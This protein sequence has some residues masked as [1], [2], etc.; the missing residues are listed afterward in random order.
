LAL[1]VA[2]KIEEPEV[3]VRLLEELVE[4]LPN[5]QQ[6]GVFHEIRLSACQ[7]KYANIR[8]QTLAGLVKHLPPDQVLQVTGQIENVEMRARTLAALVERLPSEQQPAVIEEAI[9]SAQH[10]KDPDARTRSLAELVDRLPAEQ[11]LAVARQ[12]EDPC[13]RVRAL[14]KSVGRVPSEQQLGVFQEALSAAEQIQDAFARDQ[15][16]VG[17]VE[18]LPAEQAL[19]VARQIKNAYTR[20]RTLRWLVEWL[21]PKQRLLFADEAVAALLEGIGNPAANDTLKSVLVMLTKRSL[22][23]ADR[24]WARLLQ[25]LPLRGRS[26]WLDNLAS[27]LPLVEHLGGQQALLELTN[28]IIDVRRRWP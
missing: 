8:E 10:I 4:R 23:E 26:K 19:A 22:A 27:S 5:E 13:T 6:P 16:L 7:I 11:A 2:Q 21:P 1:A 18:R 20:L 15:A 25:R 17:L 3:R 24:S 9:C 14:V 12:I 28:A